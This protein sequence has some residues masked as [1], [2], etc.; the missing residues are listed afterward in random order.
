MKKIIFLLSICSSSIFCQVSLLK[1][2]KNFH[3]FSPQIEL[4]EFDAWINKNYATNYKLE[5]AISSEEIDE[6]GF[7]HIRMQQLFNGIPVKNGMIVVHCKANQVISFNG[8]LYTSAII[9]S[10]TTT[11][12]SEA[13]LTAIQSIPSSQ[14]AWE[15]S[16]NSSQKRSPLQ[17]NRPKGTLTYIF[18]NVADNDELE[19]TPEE[20]QKLLK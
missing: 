7:K 3:Q 14:Y 8:L 1:N 5:L 2:E 19:L 12:E 9:K 11:K 16:R 20:L 13:Y 4:E 15:T 10:T 18:K 17:I 6:L